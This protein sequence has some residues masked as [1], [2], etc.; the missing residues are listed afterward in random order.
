M[1][2]VTES[3]F[4]AIS[5][6]WKRL[7]RPQVFPEK[8]LVGKNIW[9]NRQTMPFG[10]SSQRFLCVPPFAEPG[11]S[12]SPTQEV[13]GSPDHLQNLDTPSEI[14]Q[15]DTCGHF[16]GKPRWVSYISCEVQSRKRSSSTIQVPSRVVVL[17]LE[18]PTRPSGIPRGRT[19]GC[20]RYI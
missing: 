3:W 18:Y 7:F 14:Q 5:G 19:V 6:G 2:P 15:V 20:S 4:R 16:S 1:C 11:A 13:R 17:W 9:R 10:S 8:T 12:G